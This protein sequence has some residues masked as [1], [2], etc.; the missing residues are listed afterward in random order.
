VKL[1]ADGSLNRDRLIGGGEETLDRDL[2]QCK[3]ESLQGPNFCGVEDQ[4]QCSA[5]IK[6]GTHDPNILKL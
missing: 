3:F 5:K 1:T 4:K 2:I 6:S